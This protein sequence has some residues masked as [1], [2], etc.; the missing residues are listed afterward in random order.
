MRAVSSV[1][2]WLGG[3]VTIFSL[4]PILFQNGLVA[5]WIVYLIFAFCILIARSIALENDKKVAVGILTMIFVSFIGGILTLCIPIE[6]QAHYSSQ[7]NNT[8]NFV[9]GSNSYYNGYGQDASLKNELELLSILEKYEDLLKRGYI[10]QEIFDLK[11]QQ[12]LEQIT[13]KDKKT[14]AKSKKTHQI[15]EV[16]PE[17]NLDNYEYEQR[18]YGIVITGLKNNGLTHLLIPKIAIEIGESAFEGNQ[19]IT[20]VTICGNVKKIGSCAFR[21]CENLKKVIVGDDVVIIEEGAFMCCSALEDLKLG[22][23]LLEIGDSAFNACECL[24]KVVIPDAT[25]RIGEFAFCNC[26]PIQIECKRTLLN[27][28]SHQWYDDDAIVHER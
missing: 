17:N 1:F 23:S 24:N 19:T 18:E 25:E 2:S 5:V 14:T 10:T 8:L 4:A 16:E 26:S 22:S 7:P 15:E 12:I 3:V 6:K 9:D 11:K 27:R 20:S 13:P 28:I 21:C